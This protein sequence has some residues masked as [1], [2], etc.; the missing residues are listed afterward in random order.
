MRLGSVAAVAALVAVRG[1]VDIVKGDTSG[2]WHSTHGQD[3]TVAE[4]LGWKHDGYFVDVG[5][6]DP[7]VA[8]NSRA[9]ERDYGWR[10]LCI[11]ASAALLTNQRT[12]AD[13]PRRRTTCVTCR[14]PCQDVRRA[15]R[16]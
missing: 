6:S 16:C 1:E 3:R 14:R 15:R 12:T 5:A 7:H 2:S 11:E 8:S 10:G 4:L 9:L 13:H